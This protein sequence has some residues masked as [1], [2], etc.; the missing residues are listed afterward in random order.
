MDT[1]SLDKN[2]SI[3]SPKE[4]ELA[5]ELL[6]LGQGH[7]FA[8]WPAPGTDDDK[9]KS[10][11]AQIANVNSSYPGGVASYTKKARELLRASLEGANPF[12]GFEPSVPAG[13]RLKFGN[14]RFIELEKKGRPEL[15]N[16]GFVLVAGGL[17]ERLGY[18]GIK[19]ALPT[20]I[21]TETCYL[22]YYIKNILAYQTQ[23][24][25]ASGKVDLELPLAIMTSGDT[26]DLTVQLLKDNM[27]FGMAPDQITL[28]KQEKVPALMNNNAQFAMDGN[29]AIQL[30]PHGHGD[31]HVLMNSTGTATK[32]FESGVRWLLF[33]QDTNGLV[34]H[35]L[36]AALGVSAENDFAMN[37][38]TVPRRPGQALGAITTLKKGK[39]V[40]TVNVEYNQLG[41]LLQSTG[42]KKGDVADASGYSPYPG[43]CNVF[44]LRLNTYAALMAKTNGLMPEFVNPKYA[45][46]QK[47]KFK[48]PTRIEC[49]MQD[50][51][52]LLSADQKVGMTQAERWYAMEPVKNNIKD[53]A[54]KLKKSGAAESGSSGEASMYYCNREYLKESGIKIADDEKEVYCDI[55]VPYSARVVLMPSFGTTLEEVQNHV[56]GEVTVSKES[57][58]VLDG[59]IDLLNLKLDGTLI[60]KACRGAKVTIKNLTVTNDG[61]RFKNIDPNDEAMDQKYRIRGYVLDKRDQ[62]ELNFPVPGQYI[63]DDTIPLRKLNE[64]DIRKEP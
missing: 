60:V 35:A 49:M 38:V 53:A 18:K 2:L 30:K 21:S 19:V 29:Y 17:G 25:T 13:E 47:T 40:L 43:N 23:A 44:I 20:E 24:R 57:T 45:D 16:T 56:K 5:K 42:D 52:R 48:K 14:N 41:P 54:V 22:E 62:I 51:P 58:L 55:T 3:L 6:S 61:W 1:S 63:V 36:P 27:N 39:E 7:L 59:D 64:G 33:F 10:L 8:N 12:E 32:W 9:K 46:E 15:K 28:M 4:Q 31:V 26:H 34:F 11:L 50:Y 37:S